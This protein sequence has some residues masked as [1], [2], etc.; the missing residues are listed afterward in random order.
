MTIGL[1][2]IKFKPMII[3]LSL[4]ICLLMFDGIYRI[5]KKQIIKT[6]YRQAPDGLAGIVIYFQKDGTLACISGCDICKDTLTYG[7][8]KKENNCNYSAANI[9][10]VINND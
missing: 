6:C 2:D 3:L 4:I 7:T 1:R 8:W 9:Q 10:K 5:E